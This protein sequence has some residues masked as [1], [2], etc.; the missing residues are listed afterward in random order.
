LPSK[1]QTLR[2]SNRYLTQSRLQVKGC[3]AEIY[4]L[5]HVVAQW[6]MSYIGQIV[7]T[8]YGC[9][10][11]G[12]RSC[13]IFGFWPIFPIRNPKN[14]LS[15]DQPMAQGLLRRMIPIFPCG[16]RRSKGVSSGRVVSCDFWGLKTCPNV[17]LWQM[18]IGLPIQ[19]ATTRRVR[20]GP[21]MSENA[22][23]EGRMYFSTKY[24][25]P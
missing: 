5:L 14:V 11:T 21:K 13:P 6:P 18:A 1:P 25:R 24:L 12:C 9:G 8:T 20:S 2:G 10:A 4:G 3:T 19:N 17:R 23:F 15:G 16:S 7:C 22:Q